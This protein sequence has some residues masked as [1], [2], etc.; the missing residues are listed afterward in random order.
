MSSDAPA[1]TFVAVDLR[2]FLESGLLYAVNER[3]LWPLGLA[4]TVNAEEDGT[5][6]ELHVRQ[7]E[8]PDGHHECIEDDPSDGIRAT[9]Y[10]ALEEWLRDRLSSMTI[11]AERDAAAAVFADLLV[12]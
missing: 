5:I 2:E 3:L 8:Y 6:H 12:P 1:P 10:A 7:W 9:R 4:L 11:T